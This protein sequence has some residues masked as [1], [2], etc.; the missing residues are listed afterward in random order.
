MIDGVN[1]IYS[2]CMEYTV[3][4]EMK[5]TALTSEGWGPQHLFMRGGLHSIYTKEVKPTAY[6]VHMREGVHDMYL[7]EKEN[8]RLFLRDGIH[9]IRCQEMESKA[10]TREI[11]QHLV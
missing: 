7:W 1:N 2:R 5:P 10:I 8:T 3:S 6:R 4:W 11:W 9:S